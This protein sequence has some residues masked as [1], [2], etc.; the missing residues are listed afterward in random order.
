MKKEYEFPPFDLTPSNKTEYCVIFF[1]MINRL[2]SF[3]KYYNIGTYTITNKSAINKTNPVLSEPL[4]IQ[5]GNAKRT[6]KNHN[7]RF[8]LTGPFAKEDMQRLVQSCLNWKKTNGAKTITEEELDEI[9][10]A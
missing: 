9:E 1:S 7:Q 10:P 8:Y 5:I 4:I 6:V 3:F 2:H